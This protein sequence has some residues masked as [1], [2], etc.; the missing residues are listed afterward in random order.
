MYRYALP[1]A[2]VSLAA[3]PAVA[4]DCT[5][6]TE[7]YESEPC[8]DTSFS[9]TTML[10]DAKLVTDFGDLIVIGVKSEGRVTTVFATGEGAEYLLSRNGDVARFTAHSNDGPT[11][12]TYM[13]TCEGEF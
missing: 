12:I 9:L 3:L 11:S 5:F 6:T 8:Q 10:D 4:Q 7:C 13:G 2:V 1:A